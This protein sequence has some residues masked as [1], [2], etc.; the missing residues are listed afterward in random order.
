MEV[1]DAEASL[2]KAETELDLL[3]NDL[4]LLELKLLRAQGLISRLWEKN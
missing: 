3:E 1:L 4:D 2:K